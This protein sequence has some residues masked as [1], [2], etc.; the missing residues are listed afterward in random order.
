MIY[1]PIWP[2]FYI[3][4]LGGPANFSSIPFWAFHANDNVKNTQ[5]SN[6]ENQLE[7]PLFPSSNG[8]VKREANV[9]LKQ[10]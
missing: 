6:Q 10:A 5:I 2:P 9:N 8:E 7:Q 3:L 1:T 4:P